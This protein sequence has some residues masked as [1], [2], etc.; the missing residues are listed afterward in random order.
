MDFQL[1]AKHA[2]ARSLFKEFAEKEV[3][4]L[5]IEVDET[6]KF[7][8]ETVE[9]M[10]KYGF[11]GI[12]VRR[13]GATGGSGRGNGDGQWVNRNSFVFSTDQ[14]TSSQAADRLAACAFR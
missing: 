10:E 12:P 11:M 7:P 13:E 3:K 1:D 4:P 5:A 6:E 2:M 9:K 14:I 8:R